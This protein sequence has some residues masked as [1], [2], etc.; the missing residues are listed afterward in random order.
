MP[1]IQYDDMID[2]IPAAVADPALG[3][4]VL[5]RTSETSALWLDAKAVHCVD[6]FIT[7][8]CGSIKDQIVG[9]RVIRKSLAELLDD[10][11]TVRMPGD[12][13]VKNAPPVV[14]N[15][16]EAIEQAECERRNGEK[17]H[18]GYDFP[19]IA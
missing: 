18:R 3:D 14:C 4:P 2:E 19:M 16:E 13:A 15:D 12:V 11:S 7:E 8:I 1:F 5:L 9:R 17:V 6:D 10:P